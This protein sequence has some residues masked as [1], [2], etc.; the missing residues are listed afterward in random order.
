MGDSQPYGVH[1]GAYDSGADPIIQNIGQFSTTVSTG[2]D[3]FHPSMS[4]IE[5]RLESATYN[6]TVERTNWGNRAY[7]LDN[8]GRP[9]NQVYNN[10][11]CKYFDQG[12]VSTSTWNSVDDA[13]DGLFIG[14]CYFYNSNVVHVFT[15]LNYNSVG[16]FDNTFD[17]SGNHLLY[18]SQNHSVTE[19]NTLTR[20][21][22]GRTALRIDGNVKASPNQYTAVENNDMEG[23]IDPRS[24]TNFGREFTSTPLWNFVLFGLT[25]NT[26]NSGDDT[27]AMYGFKVHNNRVSG[28]TTVFQVI[29][30]RALK[31]YNNTLTSPA[32]VANSALFSLAGSFTSRPHDDLDIFDNTITYTSG[33]EATKSR[34]VFSITNF[35]QQDCAD[36]ANHTNI[37]IRGNTVTLADSGTSFITMTDLSQVP[38]APDLD[39]TGGENSLS[40][41]TNI[42]GNIINT[43]DTSAG[44]SGVCAIP[45]F[46]DPDDYV[47]NSGVAE[48][49]V[50]N[51]DGP[52]T[53]RIHNKDSNYFTALMGDTVINQV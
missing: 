37:F 1:W 9:I 24:G 46:G 29:N 16:I 34:K 39:N 26:E 27:L 33:V 45:R 32:S 7:L 4:D 13:A 30:N 10:I 38:P 52:Q 23:W 50:D 28:A 11:T 36:L 35:S 19:S 15:G 42:T 20:P 49:T 5:F 44:T 3:R 22:F 53:A 43:P 18:T 14:N 21:A 25:P 31:F 47:F 12:I 41:A 40:A 51:G 48:V 6:A 2:S 17:L 8:S